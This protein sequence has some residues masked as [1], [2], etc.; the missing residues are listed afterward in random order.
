MM[1]VMS[2]K[3]AAGACAAM[4]LGAKE[5]QA[6]NMIRPSPDMLVA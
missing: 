6:F 5:V 1:H 3:A 2:A 4:A